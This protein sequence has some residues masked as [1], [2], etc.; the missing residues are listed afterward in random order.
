MTFSVMTHKG[1]ACLACLNRV[2]PLLS[3]SDH[4]FPLPS[5][6]FHGP[7]SLA[8]TFENFHFDLRYFLKQLSST[9]TTT[10]VCQNMRHPKGFQS[11]LEIADIRHELGNFIM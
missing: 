10:V 6:V 3:S 2:H 1:T 5:Q 9:V 8:V 11:S 7:I 4:F